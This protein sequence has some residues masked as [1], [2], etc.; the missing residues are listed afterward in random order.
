[1]YDENGEP[2]YDEESGDPEVVS[3]KQSLVKEYLEAFENKPSSP[4]D[5]YLNNIVLTL[6]SKGIEI[7]PLVSNMEELVSKLAKVRNLES[8][9][10]TDEIAKTID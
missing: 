7:S 9:A 4:V 3:L 10:Y 6:K 2:I 8:F 5:V 1:V